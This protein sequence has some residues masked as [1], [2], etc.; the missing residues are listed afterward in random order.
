MQQTL[1]CQKNND[2]H[3]CEIQFQVTFQAVLASEDPLNFKI[4]VSGVYFQ[5]NTGTL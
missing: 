4:V 5:Q 3:L 1:R 2:F